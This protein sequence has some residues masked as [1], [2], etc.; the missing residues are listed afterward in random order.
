MKS[1]FYLQFFIS[2]VVKVIW[3]FHISLPIKL[4]CKLTMKSYFYLFIF[5]FF[6]SLPLK[7]SDYFYYSNTYSDQI[8]FTINNVKN[9]KSMEDYKILIHHDNKDN[10]HRNTFIGFQTAVG[11]ID[12]I[13]AYFWIYSHAEWLQIPKNI[14]K[15]WM[16]LGIK[17]FPQNKNIKILKKYV[18]DIEKYYQTDG[19]YAQPGWLFEMDKEKVFNSKEI[20]LDEDELKKITA[21]FID[22]SIENFGSILPADYIDAGWKEF[23]G[24]FGVV[25]EPMAQVLT[26]HGLKMAIARGSKFISDY[27]RNNLGVIFTDSYLQKIKNKELAQVHFKDSVTGFVI[28]NEYGVENALGGYF[29]NDIELSEEKYQALLAK[30]HELENKKHISEYLKKPSKEVSSDSLKLYQY[31]KKNLGNDIEKNIVLMNELVWLVEENILVFELKD[32]YQLYGKLILALKD[33]NNKYWQ[34]N[35]MAERQNRIKLIIEDK[36]VKKIKPNIEVSSHFYPLKN[37]KKMKFIS[38]IKNFY[39]KSFVTQKI[40]NTSSEKFALVVGNANYHTNSLKTP[41][42]D[43][44]V[45]AEKL[46]NMGFEVELYTDLDHDNFEKAL[47][48]FSKLSQNSQL[49]VIFYSGHGFQIGGQ[50]YLLPIDIDFSDK[51]SKLINHAIDIN[52]LIRENLTSTNKIIFIDACRN[53][54]LNT[55][56]LTSINVGEG[57]LVSY[58]TES[59]QFAYDGNNFLSPYTKALNM[60]INEKIEI[61]QLLRKVGNTVRINTKNKQMPYTYSN[62]TTEKLFLTGP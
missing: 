60:F 21:K 34:I 32:L 17:K 39:N 7:A 58:A 49:S 35:S 25:N 5:I 9:K 37:E 6:I 11:D 14:L 53:N 29:T 36:Y 15:G 19:S 23:I 62:L 52:S 28:E 2:L 22:I 47:L 27:A 44:N 1:Y 38:W 41:T 3:K 26:E 50:N 59:N 8:D 10:R 57:V 12:N 51:P 31:I 24:E 55:T 33:N 56:G 42:N 16:E 61:S 43:A 45:I 18:Q 48:N 40:K 30:Y 20:Y 4:I 13:N 54:P 46:K